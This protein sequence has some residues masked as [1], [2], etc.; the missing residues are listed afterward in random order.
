MPI[1]QKILHPTD[2]SENARSA[3]H[4]AC[5]M[6]REHHAILVVLHVMMPS[7]SPLQSF[8]PPDPLRAA[9]AQD[10]SGDFPWPDARD[11]EIRVE[12]RL[13]EGDPAEEIL[14]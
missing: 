4:A 14:A 3:F 5:A 6:A 8:P 2:F 12:H 9:E 7:V 1:I 11:P 10:S 13:T